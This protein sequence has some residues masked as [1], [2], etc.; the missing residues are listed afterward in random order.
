MN[1]GTET[2]GY[3]ATQPNSKNNVKKRKRDSKTQDL[4]NS[5]KKLGRRLIS[6]DMES[7]KR[8]K[9]RTGK[10]NQNT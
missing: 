2:N 10:S 1:N 6:M 7:E 5:S 8:D 4:L 9:I 3:R